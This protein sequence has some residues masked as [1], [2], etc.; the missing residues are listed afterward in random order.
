VTV[1]GERV[2]GFS[3]WVRSFRELHQRARTATL[4]PGEETRYHSM[5]EELAR[6]MLAAQKLTLKPGETPR[7]ALRVARAIQIDLKVGA[8]TERTVTLDLSTGGFSAMLA[9]PP[10][11][12]ELVGVSLR[13]PGGEPL[14]CRAS[15]TD[16]KPLAGSVRVAGSFVDLKSAD[17]ERLE[18]FVI[19]A[20]LSLLAA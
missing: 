12:G 8:T 14:A 4:G 19:D 3:D 15:I 1:G 20:V 18:F 2:G 11:L 13:V 7:R 6:A 9:R 16:I 5:R 10:T 17:L